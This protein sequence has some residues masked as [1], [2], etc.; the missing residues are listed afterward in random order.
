MAFAGAWLA[1]G[2]LRSDYDPVQQAISRLAETGA[3]TRGLMSAGFV[4]FSAGVL[5]AA[6]ALG[7]HVS[8]T[9]GIAAAATALA[10]AGVALTPLHGD[11]ANGAHNAFAVSGYATLAA[12]PLLAAGSLARRGFRSTSAFSAVTG[13][14][15]AVMLASTSTGWA[16]G[17]LQRTGLICGHAWLAVASAALATGRFSRSTTPRR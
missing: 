6:P 9:A 8:R 11:A 16:A 3:S 7:R 10:T 14:L 15:T 13:V 12:A 17:L 1:G 5:I 2:I 4:A